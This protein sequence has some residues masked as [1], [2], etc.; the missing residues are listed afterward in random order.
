MPWFNQSPFQGVG[1]PFSGLLPWHHLGVIALQWAC[2]SQSDA[3]ALLRRV[4]LGVMHIYFEGL[5]EE[6][7]LLLPSLATALKLS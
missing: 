3:K 7:G 6:R 4:V 1:V 2:A 5:L